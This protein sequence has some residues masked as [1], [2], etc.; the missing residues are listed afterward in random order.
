MKKTTGKTGIGSWAVLL[1]GALWG[2]GAHAQSSVTL[3][4]ELDTGLIYTNRTLG[5]GGANAGKQF[6]LINSGLAPSRFGLTGVED[7]GGGLAAR[8]RL[9]SGIDMVN[10]GFD[11]S[12]G[13]LFGR[14]AWVSLEG[15]FG[16]LKI[17]EQYSP[18]E[19]ALF[20]L[21]PRSFAQ[22][23]SSI[24][25]YANNVFT[26]IFDSN[27]LSWT[28]PKLAGF[29]ASVLTVLGGV[30]GNF[31]AGRQYSARLKYEYGGLLVEGAI[32]DD[33]ESS[34][35]AIDT[36]P[37]TTPVEA[38]SLGVAYNFSVVT[39]KASFAH[40]NAPIRFDDGARSGGDNNVYN[41][42]FNYH[43]LS[44]LDLNAS[45]FYIDDRHESSS[46]SL[47]AALGTQYFL[48]KH[49]SLYAQAGMVQN[50]GTENIGLALDGAMHA[51]H[52]TSVGATVGITHGF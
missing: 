17:G 1:A 41:V 45:V 40:Y 26:G 2:A 23:G 30:P 46:H 8:F 19:D 16:S 35:A 32:L 13:N 27:A 52:G 7:L 36:N 6:S 33:A 34:D 39:V 29:T 43:L 3:Y 47:L 11:N 4:G 38:H 50:R 5:E 10:G 20:D 24:L 25:V 18:Y 48:S 21:D 14:Q 31:A 22:F 9:E 51:P 42:G 44:N 15:G 49:T 28:S 37:L 12:N